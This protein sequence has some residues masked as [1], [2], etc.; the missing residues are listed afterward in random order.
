MFLVLVRLLPYTV[1]LE[2][3]EILARTLDAVKRTRWNAVVWLSGPAEQ[4]CP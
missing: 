3:E 2:E 1:S 4:V